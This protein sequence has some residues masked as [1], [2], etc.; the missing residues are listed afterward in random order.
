MGGH[1]TVAVP[2]T[3]TLSRKGPIGVWVPPPGRI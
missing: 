2:S 3:Y 1:S